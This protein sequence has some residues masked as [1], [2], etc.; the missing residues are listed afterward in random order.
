[1]SRARIDELVRILDLS[2]EGS[3]HS[4]VDNLVTVTDGAQAGTAYR[5]IEVEVLDAADLLE[6]VVDVL[7]NAH[8]LIGD[9][10]FTTR[11]PQTSMMYFETVQIQLIE[12]LLRKSSEA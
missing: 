9:Y 6:P 7:T 8:P 12:F 4:L 5:E 2:F 11:E 10:P 3:L 1:M